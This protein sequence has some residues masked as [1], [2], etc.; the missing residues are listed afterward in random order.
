LEQHDGVVPELEQHDGVMPELEQYDGVVPEAA[1]KADHPNRSSALAGQELRP[2]L[3]Q[4]QCQK[5]AEPLLVPVVFWQCRMPQGQEQQ[6][7]KGH[8]RS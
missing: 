3:A 1:A 2:F 8:V 6:G 4:F 5:R 7:L